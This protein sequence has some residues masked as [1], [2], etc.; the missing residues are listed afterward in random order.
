M[1]LKVSEAWWENREWKEGCRGAVAGLTCGG[2]QTVW[3]AASL[4]H[5]ETTRGTLG[6]QD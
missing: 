2:E 3:R 4:C 6:R 1:G 5:S